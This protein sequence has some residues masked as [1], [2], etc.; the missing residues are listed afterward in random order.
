MP[1]QR[2]NQFYEKALKLD[3]LKIT[4]NDQNVA[5]TNVSI[6]AAYTSLTLPYTVTSLKICELSLG[7]NHIV[8][9]LILCYLGHISYKARKVPGSCRKREKIEAREYGENHILSAARI[10]HFG[11]FFLEVRNISKAIASCKRVLEI[12]AKSAHREPLRDSHAS[13]SIGLAYLIMGNAE[14]AL[15]D[16][17]S[18]LDTVRSILGEQ[19]YYTAVSRASYGMYY[20]RFNNLNSAESEFK[21]AIE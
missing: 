4:K 20:H 13:Q 6:G 12:C 10:N 8:S 15:P 2:S 17:Q 1:L 9:S 3:G 14:R 5:F 11:D 7:E 18:S 19:H 16:L 21:G